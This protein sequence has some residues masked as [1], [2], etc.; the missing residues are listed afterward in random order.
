MLQVNLIIAS[1]GR[2][3]IPA[4]MRAELGVQ[5]GGRLVARLVDGTVVLEPV[6]SA[7]RRAQEMVGRYVPRDAQLVEELIAERHVA[8]THE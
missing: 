5:N 8:A 1:N 2:V 4:I 7:V 6:D 3:V